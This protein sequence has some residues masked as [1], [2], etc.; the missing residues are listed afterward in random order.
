[1]LTRSAMMPAASK[2]FLQ[3]MHLYDG[4]LLGLKIS[5]MYSTPINGAS[6]NLSSVSLISGS[7]GTYDPPEVAGK[8]SARDINSV[9][10]LINDI[11]S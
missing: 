9:Y 3:I 5:T 2:V 11:Q 10:N 6:R 7:A 1:M 8:G 4:S